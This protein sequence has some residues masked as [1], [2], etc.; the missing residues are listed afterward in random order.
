MVRELVLLRA[1]K[2]VVGGL[3][4]SGADGRRMF[5]VV[6][7]T[8]NPVTG[9]THLCVYCWA[10]RLAET[11]LRRSPRYRDGFVPRFNAEEL[12]ARFRPGELVFVSDMG[13]LFCDHV[14]D[15]WIRRVL[16]HMARFPET[17]CLLLTKNPERY[18][19]FLDEMPPNA[20]LGATIET[21]RDDMYR[22]RRI[23]GA[24]L[25]SFRYRAMSD[26][27]WPKKFISIE[28]ILDFDLEEFAGWIEE[29][30]PFMVYVGYD[31]YG[32]RLPEPP[33]P[34]TLKLIERLERTVLVVRKALRPAWYETLKAYE[35]DNGEEQRS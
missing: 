14:E 15:G 2:E 9:C 5:S 11:R 27:A 29:I 21:N 1:I 16:R 30:G 10:R 19:D 24:P 18:F 12:R 7:R 4:N 32:N 23:S 31:N 28:P 33:L 6:T 8:W 17:H 20:I 34:K 3:L 25:P 26:L 22:E 35:G 13:D